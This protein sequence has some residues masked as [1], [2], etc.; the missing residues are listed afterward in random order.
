MSE[1]S[2]PPIP[3]PSGDLCPVCHTAYE[4]RPKFC[5]HCGA[6]LSQFSGGVSCWRALAAGVL[7][8]LALAFGGAGACF[9]LFASNEFGNGQNGQTYGIVAFCFA[10][11]IGCLWAAWALSRSKR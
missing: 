2:N 9:L 7:V 1:F 5:P 3:L 8:L 10:V 6:V 11:T 4:G